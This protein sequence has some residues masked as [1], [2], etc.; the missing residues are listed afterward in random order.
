MMSSAEYFSSPS[1]H[2]VFQPDLLA[3]D[4]VVLQSLLD[5]FTFRSF[6]RRL[7]LHA[8]EELREF[9]ERIVDA[10]VAFKLALVVNQLARDFQ[11]LFADAVQRLD[12]AR[13]DDRGVESGFDCIV[14]KH[15]IQNH[16]RGRIQTERDIR[17]TE[18]GERARKFSLDPFDGLDRFERVAAILFDAG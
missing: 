9:G 1:R 17:D 18:N 5:S 3:V 15:G 10:N 13:V 8:F 12:L 7:R 14:E 6:L 16:S 2:F 11:F 4:D